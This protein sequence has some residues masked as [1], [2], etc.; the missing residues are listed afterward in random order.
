MKQRVLQLIGSFQSGGS[1]RQALQL[2]GLLK[3]GGRYDVEIACLDASGP[4]GAEAHRLGFHEIQEY[5]LSSF[6]SPGAV[7]QLQR[8]ARWLRSKQIDIVQTHDFY[9]NV[10]GMAGGWLALVPVRIAAKRETTGWRTPAQKKVEQLSYRLAHA[11]VANSAAVQNQLEREGVDSRKT[12][13][14]HNGVDPARLSVPAEVSETSIR[15]SIGLPAEPSTQ[16]VTIVANLRHPVKGH[17]VFL[18]AAEAV[19]KTIGDCRFVIAG[20]GELTEQMKSLAAALGLAR[21][22]SFIGRCDNIAGLLSISSVCVLSSHAE[23]FSNSILEYMAASRPVVATNVGGA[24]EAIVEGETGYLVEPGDHRAMA[25]R[26]TELVADPALAKR[27]GEH[28][29]RRVEFEFTCDAQLAR[30]ERLYD[31]LLNKA[32]EARAMIGELPVRRNIT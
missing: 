1:E 3:Q 21:R 18:R 32:G 23:G 16:L 13:V 8:F 22:V 26:V 2:A 19:Q 24:A 12:V 17:D 7:K 29:R 10:F 6:Y 15:Q 27:M 5:R 30:T 25:A 4:L 20:E 11:V 9:T 14:I 28:G 31:R